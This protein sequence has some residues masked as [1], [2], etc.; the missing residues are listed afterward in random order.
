MH[1]ACEA[2][3]QT[4]AQLKQRLVMEASKQ[5][6][7][8]GLPLPNTPWLCLLASF[9]APAL[10]F[11]FVC[12]LCLCVRIP[13]HQILLLMTLMLFV[14][15]PS[16]GTVQIP[17]YLV[18]HLICLR[19]ASFVSFAYQNQ[20]HP[21]SWKRTSN[22]HPSIFCAPVSELYLHCPLWIVSMDAARTSATPQ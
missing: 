16:R 14:S 21:P 6:D 4:V 12:C 9:H 2:L 20:A 8:T 10:P 22:A 15:K 7:L 19:H 11:G 5:M 3:Q 18:K 13:S 17:F 1:G